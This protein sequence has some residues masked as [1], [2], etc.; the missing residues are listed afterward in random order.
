MRKHGQPHSLCRVFILTPFLTNSITLVGA[1][2]GHTPEVAADLSSGGFSDLF[3][4]PT[5]Q[6]D[7]VAQYLTVLGDEYEGLFNPN[8][9]AYPDV[10]AQGTDFVI[11][12]DG[13][14]VGVDGTSASSPTIAS[15]VA[16]VN[17]ERLNAGKSSLGFLNP[18]LYSDAAAPI[19]NDI[20]A[21]SNPGC[22]TNGFPAKSGW[23]PVRIS[24][25]R[26]HNLLNMTIDRSLVSEAL[27]TRGSPRWRVSFLECRLSRG[28]LYD[29]LAMQMSSTLNI[30]ILC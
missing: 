4:R 30:M 29:S 11:V 7:A 5:Y 27:T 9:R 19:F 8:G 16:L 23:D 22:S 14:Y 21:G 17:D 10:A 24:P 3:S 26:H 28:M 25:G 12:A 6:Q 13:Q 18:L 15:I 1:T 2:T 20:T